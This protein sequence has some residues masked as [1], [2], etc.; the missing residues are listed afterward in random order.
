MHVRL[1]G[2][3]SVEFY[4]LRGPPTQVRPRIESGELTPVVDPIA[5]LTRECSALRLRLATAERRGRNSLY[6]PSTAPISARTPPSVIFDLALESAYAHR[7]AA[8]LHIQSEVM[9]LADRYKTLEKTLREMQEAL[10][11]KDKE[12]EV[13]RQERDKLIAERDQARLERD[14]ERVK[15]RSENGPSQNQNGADRLP[16][17]SR[18]PSRS[19]AQ[20]RRIEPIPPLPVS[21][22]TSMD[23]EYHAR[24]YSMDIFL[25]K[26]DNWSGAQVIQAV[27]DLHE[28]P[29]ESFATA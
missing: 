13:L 9:K 12:I 16:N 5:R 25:T 8:R 10:R 3:S 4:T 15:P 19:R 27:E 24:T 26:T 29:E 20:V 11:V 6:G 22:R 1:P 23:A 14:Q 28:T 7:D 18:E 2:D 17:R 21:P